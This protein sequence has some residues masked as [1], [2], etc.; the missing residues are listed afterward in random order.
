MPRKP[1]LTDEERH[2][3]FKEM[4]RKVEASENPDAFDRA[5]DKVISSPSDLPQ[6]EKDSR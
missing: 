2:D 5:F 4:A 1:N 6:I 3:R